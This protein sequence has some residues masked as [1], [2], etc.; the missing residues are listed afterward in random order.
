MSATCHTFVSAESLAGMLGDPRLRLFDCRSD[1]MRPEAGA[2][3]YAA[4]HLPGARFADLNR[5]LA[6]PVT[7]AS[8]RHPLPSPEI[9]AATLRGWGVDSDSRVVAYDERNGAYAARLWWMLRWLGHA[10]TSVLDGGYARWTDL[11]LPVTT[12][13]PPPVRAGS[14][15]AHVQPSMVVDAAHVL[16]A[17]ASSG[18]RVLDARGAER[19]RGDVEPIDR[20]AGHI[21]GARNLPYTTTISA[22]G[23]TLEGDALA[24]V[25]DAADPDAAPGETVVM[26]GSGVTACRLLLALEHAGRSGAKLYPG[27]WSEW[28]RDPRRPIATGDD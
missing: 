5:D 11:G 13:V 28:I 4:G 3:Q 2:E 25:L 26:C 22:D 27:S 19:F 23:R 17:T 21:P 6:A 14:F 10:Q 7:S 8:G 1:L 15:A 12:E 9:F 20:V 16:A 18:S 24:H